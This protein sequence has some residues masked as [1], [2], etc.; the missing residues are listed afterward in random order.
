MTSIKHAG[1]FRRPAMPADAREFWQLPPHKLDSLLALTHQ[2][3][4][5]ELKLVV[6]VDAHAAACASLGADLSGASARRVYY[7]DTADLMLE[8]HGVVARVRRF[9]KGSGD[10]VVKLRPI[11]PDDLPARWRRSKRFLVEVDAM[12]GR[13][14]CTGAL[15][16]RLDTVDVERA[17]S[18]GP[19]LGALF[20]QEQ[21]ALLAAYVPAPFAIAELRVFGPVRVRR[22]RVRPRG[23]GGVLA[24]ERWS[25]PDGSSILELSTRCP[26][27]EAVPVAA[28]VASLLRRYGIDVADCRQT[29]TRATLAYFTGRSSRRSDERNCPTCFARPGSGIAGVCIHRHRPAPCPS[30]R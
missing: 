21:L 25:Y 16:R 28:R 19:S 15:K 3:D 18:D 1:P 7:L 9:E 27:E 17:L 30:P 24:V 2:A 22:C 5:M 11:T 4:Q 26:A 23:L 10:F 6:P 13:Y 20:S 14:F 8:R 29:K 12:P